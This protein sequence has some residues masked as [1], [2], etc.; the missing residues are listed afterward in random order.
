M[1]FIIK[2]I[3]AS[4]AKLLTKTPTETPA[5][6]V[7]VA[8]GYTSPF[9]TTS[10]TPPTLPA[11]LKTPVL[12]TPAPRTVVKITGTIIRPM[13]AKVKDQSQQVKQ[14]DAALAGLTAGEVAS[15]SGYDKYPA[16]A[17][18]QRV[19][20]T[21]SMFPWVKHYRPGDE[22]IVELVHPHHNIAYDDPVAYRMHT[23]RI[24]SKGPTEGSRAALFR[25]E[26]DVAPTTPQPPMPSK[27][28]TN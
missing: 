15:P 4:V 9:K 14:S 1:A 20:I 8:P 23:L 25:H 10:I 24:V 3:G 13:A 11:V 19:K 22:A 17:I 21:N 7:E 12:N 16:V 18:G 2:R 6:P 28:I 5:A 26:F 27:F